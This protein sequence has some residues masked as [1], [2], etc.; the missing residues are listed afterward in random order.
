MTNT[1]KFVARANLLVRI[2]NSVQFIGQPANYVNRSKSLL[3]DGMWGYPANSTPYEVPVKS[4]DAER[5]IVLTQR[6]AALWPY[7]EETAVAC[8]TKYVAVECLDGEWV[9]VKPAKLK[10]VANEG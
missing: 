6:D 1:L 2:P 5:L 4:P 8:D 9:P 10:K 7:D 3:P